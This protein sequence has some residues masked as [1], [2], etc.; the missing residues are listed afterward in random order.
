[1]RFDR[2]A[3]LVLVAAQEA[4]AVAD[5]LVLARQPPVDDLLLARRSSRAL[6]HAQIPLAQ[7]AHLLGV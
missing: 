2:L 1:V 4:L 7:Q 6:A 3:D 5:G